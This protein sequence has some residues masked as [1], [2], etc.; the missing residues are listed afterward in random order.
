MLQLHHLNK[1]IFATLCGWNEEA[2]FQQGSFLV[3]AIDGFGRGSGGIE[4]RGLGPGIVFNDEE[5]NC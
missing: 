4:L 2:R 1:P 5:E 3:G